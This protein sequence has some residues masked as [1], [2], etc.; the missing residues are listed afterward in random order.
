MLINHFRLHNPSLLSKKNKIGI[1]D[2]TAL[3][4]E[5]LA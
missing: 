4:C 2:I 3:K 5:K 1:I